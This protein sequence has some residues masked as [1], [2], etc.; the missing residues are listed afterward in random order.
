MP[1]LLVRICHRLH[2][3]P[4]SVAPEQMEELARRPWRGNVRE[5]LNVLERA[6]VS[7]ERGAPCG[8]RRASPRST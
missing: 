2:R 7:T 3:A 8:C 4:L 1:H 5:L 6:V